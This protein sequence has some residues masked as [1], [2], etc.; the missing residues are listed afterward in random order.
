MIS[1]TI[2]LPDDVADQALAAGLL[3]SQQLLSIF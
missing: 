3:G 1:I 2:E